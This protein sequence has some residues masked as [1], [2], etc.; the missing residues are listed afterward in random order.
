MSNLD[1]LAYVQCD[2]LSAQSLNGHPRWQPIVMGH[3]IVCDGYVSGKTT[4]VFTH[5]HEDHAWNF[6]S[7]LRRCHNVLLTEPTYDAIK[8]LKNFAERPTIIEKLPYNRPF[9]TDKHETIELIKAN[10]VSGSCQVLVTMDDT[11]DRILYSGDFSFPEISVPEAD[12]LVVDG[13]H[14]TPLYNFDTDKP[15]VL[16]RIFTEVSQQIEKNRPVEILA[17]RGTM[18]DIMAQLEQTVDGDFIPDD[19]PF[20]ADQ[21]DVDL[22]N[23]IKYTYDDTEFRNIEVST[24]SKFNELYNVDKKPF[25][26]FSRP[27][28]GSMQHDRAQV[29]QADVNQWFKKNGPFWTDKNGKIYACLAAH[30]DYDNVLKYVE[31]VKPKKVIVD[32]T[33]V[34]L[35]TA[36]SLSNTINKKLKIRSYVDTCIK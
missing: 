2:Q 32:G 5:F 9:P 29:I 6:N 31:R 30:S 22:T 13:T 33:R 8:A 18:Q 12:I 36:Q 15:S 16:R 17:N 7:A 14:G 23:A 4:A 10:H 25:V 35:E 1:D 21:S 28:M 34:N 26:K 27:G 19:I 3:S 11:G 24:N 20:F